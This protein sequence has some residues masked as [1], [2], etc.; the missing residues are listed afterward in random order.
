MSLDLM[1]GEGDE[2]R[3]IGMS[4]TSNSYWTER[5]SKSHSYKSVGALVRYQI[6]I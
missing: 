1:Y 5:A 4:F 6:K 2:L 3:L